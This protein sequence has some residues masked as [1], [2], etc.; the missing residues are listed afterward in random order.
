VAGSRVVVLTSPAHRAADI[1]FD[2]LA[3]DRRYRPMAA[4]SRSKLANLLF[5]QALQAK[6]AQ[7]HAPTLAVATHPG[8]AR[9]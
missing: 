6:L 1:D 2:D 8:G 5:A 9:T 7:A 3:Y 4:Y